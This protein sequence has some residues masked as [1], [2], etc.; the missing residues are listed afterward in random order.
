MKEVRY[1]TAYE[2]IPLFCKESMEQYCSGDHARLQM[3]PDMSRFGICMDDG[4]KEGCFHFMIAG[5]CTG[6]EVPEDMYVVTIPELPWA[7]FTCVGPLPG[8]LQAVN[9]KIF[10]RMAAKEQRIRYRGGYEYRMV[11][12]ERG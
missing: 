4:E 12:T 10:F 6:K 11:Y 7:K 9:T 1:E 5:T 3:I 2:A 8:A